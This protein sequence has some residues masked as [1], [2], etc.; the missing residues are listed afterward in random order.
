MSAAA[1]PG[2]DVP[3]AVPEDVLRA[4]AYLLR[5]AEPPCWDLV[6]F[7]ERFGPVEAAGRIRRGEVPGA[8]AERVLARRGHDRVDAD[9]EAARA[10]G[11][12]L[13]VPE[14]PAWPAWPFGA[15]GIANDP[16]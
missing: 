14:D 9:L 5:V 1:T 11:A 7:V 13:L 3:A 15:F 8:V 12:R 4:R 10:A 6:R 16:D 2:P